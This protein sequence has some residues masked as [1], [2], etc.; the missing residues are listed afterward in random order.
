[1]KPTIPAHTH[2]DRN[3]NFIKRDSIYPALIVRISLRELI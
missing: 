3:D 2:F 1:M